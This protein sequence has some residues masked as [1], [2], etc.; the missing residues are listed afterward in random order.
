MF[1]FCFFHCSEQFNQNDKEISTYKQ[2][3]MRLTMKALDIRNLRMR[4]LARR[5]MES[6]QTTCWT[7][8][9]WACEAARG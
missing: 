5:R 2:K 9:G 3:W 1:Y 8:R 6:S 4:L 7:G